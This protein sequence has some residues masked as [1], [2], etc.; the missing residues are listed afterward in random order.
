MTKGKLTT[1]QRMNAKNLRSKLSTLKQTISLN[2][3][4]IRKDIDEDESMIGFLQNILY[5]LKLTTGKLKV[6]RAINILHRGD[7]C[8]TSRSRLSSLNK[9]VHNFA[10]GGSRLNLNGVNVTSPLSPGS[11]LNKT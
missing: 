9:S 8:N 11:I 7:S 5:E 4:I 3:N 2:Q 10:A 1:G 6:N